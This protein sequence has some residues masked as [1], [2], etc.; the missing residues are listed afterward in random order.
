MSNIR[1][2][3]IQRHPTD[4][5]GKTSKETAQK[6]AITTRWHSSTQNIQ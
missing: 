1:Q 3:V 5:K 4:P 6:L 2:Q